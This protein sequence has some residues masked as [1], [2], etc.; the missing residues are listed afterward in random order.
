MKIVCLDAYSLYPA[1]DA[2]WGEFAD[3]GDIEVYDRTRADEIVDRATG[4]DVILTNKVPLSATTL[5]KL[6][7]LKFICVLATG[8]NI[9]DVKAAAERGIPVSNIPSY[10]TASVAQHAISLLLAITNRV[11]EYARCNREGKWQACEDFTFSQHSLPE[12]SGKKF[13]VVGF[14]HTGQATAAIAAALGMEILVFTS[15][16]QN[17]LPAGYRKVS[18]DELFS[19]SDVVSLHCPLTDSTRNLVNA[20]RLKQMKS[21]AILLNTSR[22]PVVNEADLVQALKKGEIA[23]A[24]LDVLC[25]E[26]PEK[27]NELFTLSN[28]YITPHIAWAS[29][30]AKERLFAIAL[31]NVADFAKGHPSNVVN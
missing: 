23:A 22:G 5:A 20:E 17:Q 27:D 3:F 14:G 18:L 25:K 31:T 29:V 7:D 1:T 16:E 28:C 8:F 15:K 21:S 9:V 11:E 24:G 30:E 6:P 13:G 26:P 4:A 2:R 10:S 12:L 19:E